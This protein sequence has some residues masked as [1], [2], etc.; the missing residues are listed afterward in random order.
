MISGNSLKVDTKMKAYKLVHDPAVLL[1]LI[2]SK[3]GDIEEDFDLLYINQLVYDK[4][5][6]YNILFKEFQF[7]NMDDEFLKRF[8]Q[9]YESRPRIPKLSDYYKNYHKFFCRP[10]FKD[11]I[12]SDL[13]ENYG[14]DKAELFYKNNFDNSNTNEISGKNISD[15]LSSLDN[16]TDN[17]IIFTKKTKKI[18]D[19][20]L[21]NN[22]GTLTL[23]SNSIS[24]INNDK[25]TYKSGLISSRS[26]NDSFEKIVH[27]LIYYEKKQIRFDKNKRNEINKAVKK[28]IQPPK[29]LNNKVGGSYASK[30]I[31]K[32]IIYSLKINNN[33][34]NAI[35]DNMNN[36]NAKNKN[37]LFSLLKSKNLIN[38][39]KT[40]NNINCNN[41]SRKRKNISLNLNKSQNKNNKQNSNN[42]CFSNNNK[43]P[44]FHLATKL[45]EFH[46]NVIRPNTSFFHKRNKTV[47]FD[48]QNSG[49]NNTPSI[50]SNT[51]NNHY[52]YTLNNILSRNN[53]NI[54]SRNYNDNLK[55]SNNKQT[56]FNNYLTINNNNNAINQQ[57]GLNDMKNRV[58]NKTFEAE[59]MK[60]NIINKIG[61]TKDGFKVY[62]K[63]KINYQ[64]NSNNDL[65]QIM[66]KKNTLTRN[67][68]SKFSL[69]KNP[70][71]FYENKNFINKNIKNNLKSLNT[72][73][74]S[75]NSFNKNVINSKN[76]SLHKKS[77]TTI[78]S[79]VLESS[80]KNHILSPTHM[81]KQQ[82]KIHTINKSE[83]VVS[84]MRP[85][86]NT[87]KISNLNI[88]FNN[89]IFNAPLSNINQNIHY[90]N[91][92][93]NN[94]NNENLSYK[95]LTPNNKYYNFNKTFSNNKNNNSNLTN[96]NT[97]KEPVNEKLHHITN[98]K[99]FSDF[100]RNKNYYYG[101]SF[102]QNDDN[103]SLIKKNYSNNGQLIYD[104]Y[105]NI[106]NTCYSLNPNEKTEIFKK[107][108]ID[109]I[110]QKTTAGKTISIKNGKKP[111]NKS[112]KTKKI[113]ESR[114]QNFGQNYRMTDNSKDING[115][116][117]FKT[118]DD[119][120]NFD[121]SKTLYPSPK[122]T[123]RNITIQPI[124]VNRNTNLISRKAVK[125]KQKIKMK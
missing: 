37:S 52:L 119:Y 113:I 56:I 47:Y 88:N 103:F 87:N 48:K 90:N 68:G 9:R 86:I 54:N 106:S 69:T 101:Q 41:I 84:K 33:L 91:T 104:K 117:S 26:V 8:Y 77:Q 110:I 29:K 24:N 98:L 81:N 74:S 50:Q 46:V 17:K 66:I 20:N 19:H 100:S 124:N 27:N 102:T 82:N 6:R 99:N 62:Y 38:Y 55:Y 96:N 125:T 108:K 12:I 51:I 80:S 60:N 94:N 2:Y 58:K 65:D 121:N 120:R 16:I 4:S 53:N 22:C 59:G 85:K 75:L 32:N 44:R 61:T 11:F 43:E 70:L 13:M 21:D 89:V 67:N 115:N 114:N 36:R 107:K 111:T 49:I 105:K 116:N 15:S 78:L 14:D 39:I 3:Y 1:N 122:T 93:G 72:K 64:N 42:I 10:N 123:G 18:I 35:N 92:Y 5:S 73:I 97:F 76:I 40:E 25:K 71:K 31:N 7:L 112:Q 118:K 57:R 63:N 95:L 28:C 30:K 45:E 34:N 23:T 109:L 79:N 83:N